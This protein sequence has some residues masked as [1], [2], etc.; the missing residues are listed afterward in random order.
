MKLMIRSNQ[1]ITSY[2]LYHGTSPKSMVQILETNE[3]RA[4]VSNETETNRISFTRN[5]RES[6]DE[7]DLVV[8]RYELSHNYHIEPVYREGIAG[9]DLAEESCDRTI[10]NIRKYIKQIR[11]TNP[12]TLKYLK[13]IKDKYRSKLITDPYFVKEYRNSSQT[14]PNDYYWLYK[15]VELCNKY[16]IKMN[17]ALEQVGDILYTIVEE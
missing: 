14:I 8:D 1:S 11:L 7:V 9:R 13:R 12:F 2:P 6:Y 16:N 15:L 5:S 4:N 3:L 10:T 17:D